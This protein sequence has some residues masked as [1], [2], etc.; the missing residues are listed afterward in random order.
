MAPPCQGMALP[1]GPGVS[2]SKRKAGTNVKRLVPTLPF[3]SVVTLGKSP[4]LPMSQFP[5]PKSPGLSPSSH[6]SGR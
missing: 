6:A 5:L 2:N 4:D 3:M 1:C